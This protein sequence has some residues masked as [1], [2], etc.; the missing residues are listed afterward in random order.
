MTVFVITHEEE[1]AAQTKRIVR[2]K[3]GVIISDELTG[4]AKAV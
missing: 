2:L 4:K 1:I 3:D